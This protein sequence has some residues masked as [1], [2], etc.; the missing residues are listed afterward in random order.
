M[1]VLRVDIVASHLPPFDFVHLGG[2]AQGK[3]VASKR[4][5][6]TRESRGRSPS[7]LRIN[8]QRPYEGEQNDPQNSKSMENSTWRGPAPSV[9]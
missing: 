7:C 6:A 3:R 5:N 2:Q 4:V 1:T 8:K 9:G